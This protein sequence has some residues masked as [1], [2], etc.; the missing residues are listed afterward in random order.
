MYYSE[1]ELN[2]AHLFTCEYL[3][4]VNTSNDRN[5]MLKLEVVG[6]SYS[7][8]SGWSSKKDNCFMMI[9]FDCSTH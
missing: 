4:N 9:T 2:C 5:F 7:I 1:K 3:L 6:C 8:D